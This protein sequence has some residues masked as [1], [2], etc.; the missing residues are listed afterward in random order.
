MSFDSSS[1]NAGDSW[2]EGLFDAQLS[3]PLPAQPAPAALPVIRKRDGSEAP[4]DRRAIAEAI[5]EAAQVVGGEDRDLA[6]SLASAV[7]I[8][9]GKRFRHGGVPTVDHVNDAVERVLIQM[10]HARTALAYARRRDRRAR[11]RRLREGDV[12]A[13]FTEL[14]EARFEREAAEAREEGLLF[15]RQSAETPL[16]W[17]G[18]HTARALARE[19]GLSWEQAVSVARAVERQLIQAGI[20]QVTV[21]LVR[22]LAGAELLARGWQ[23]AYERRQQL[24]LSLQDTE[25]VLRGRTPETVSQHPGATGDALARAVKREYAL[26]RVMPREI[27]EAHLRGAIHLSR[28]S[29]IDRLGEATH[30]LAYVA[31]HGVWAP[32]G[33]QLAPPA[34]HGDTLLAHMVKWDELMRQFTSGATRWA[35]VN[36]FFAPFLYGL[37]PPELRQF[38]QMLL[39]EYAYRALAGPGQR[40]VAEIEVVWRVPASLRGVCIVGP[41]GEIMEDTYGQFEHTVQQFGWAIVEELLSAA[42][43]GAPLP[44]PQVAVRLEEAGARVAGQDRF[45]ELTSQ[46]IAA[47]APLVVRLAREELGPLAEP[48]LASGVSLPPVVLNLA[49]AAYGCG[50]ADGMDAAL[51]PLLSLAVQAHRARREFLETLA[52]ER[53]GPLGM[54]AAVDGGEPYVLLQAAACPVAVEGLREAVLWLTGGELG[55]EAVA[56]ACG[57]AILRRLRERC[58]FFARRDEVAL[59]LWEN[60]RESVGQR[61]ATVDAAEFP[62]EARRVLRAAGV[63]APL[64]YTAGVGLSP[65]AGLNP[66]ERAQVESRLKA[67]LD[68]AVPVRVSLPDTNVGAATIGGFVARLQRETPC[69]AVVF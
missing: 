40:D 46:A 58:D 16:A 25:N 32:G 65:Q 33:R 66:W 52:A 42:M 68:G 30:A 14:E 67:L 24:G 22:E 60:E 20:R 69:R 49:R 9:L 21:G 56:T 5:F 11:I 18:E 13:L 43:E 55:V 63:D 17:D 50:G 44:A 61:F 6:Y 45:L 4:F 38:A 26:A 47:G 54:I 12:R 27:T 41:S 28:L 10:S 8:Y 3:L 7:E 39:Y 1:L 19:L 29:D 59:C 36:V 31:R 35:A 2:G 64:A 15:S 48:W 23:E 57:E 62:E 34:A 51:E 37:E 53:T